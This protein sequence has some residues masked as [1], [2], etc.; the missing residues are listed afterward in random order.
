MGREVTASIVLGGGGVTG[1]AWLIGVFAG[2]QRAGFA[3]PSSCG[4]IG[5]SAGSVVCTQLAQGVSPEA[6]LAQQLQEEGAKEA[7]RPYSQR[8][9][10]A[11]NRILVDKVNGDLIQA[12]KRIGAFALRS[13]TPSL[14]ERRAIIRARLSEYEWPERPLRLTAVNVE[15]AERVVLD[16]G[17]GLSLL[18]AVMASCAV[19]GAW[20]AVPVGDTKLMDGGLYSMT[21]AD[22]ALESDHV[23]ILAPLGY[24]DGNPVS[25]HLRAEVELLRQAGVSVDLIVPDEESAKA[26]GDNVLDPAER[27]TSAAA[28]LRQGMATQHLS[29]IWRR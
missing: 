10:D 4:F 21:N 6:L 22:L 16:N 20:P 25:G 23:L 26:I 1:I 8:D 29:A 19:P 15:S 24:S 9:S 5:T 18:D 27:A 11:K 14:D 12:R 28:G 2:M 7:F 3:I 17:A 13:E